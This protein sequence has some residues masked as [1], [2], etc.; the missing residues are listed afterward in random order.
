M[1]GSSEAQRLC[2]MG[3]IRLWTCHP[4]TSSTHSQR[5]QLLRA[6]TQTYLQP[7]T[8]GALTNCKKD[9]HSIYSSVDTASLNWTSG[10]HSLVQAQLPWDLALIMP[11]KARCPLILLQKGRVQPGHSFQ[12]RPQQ[13]QAWLSLPGL[14]SLGPA[15]QDSSHKVPISSQGE[16]RCMGH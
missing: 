3:A 13:P 10:P 4:E 6:R 9:N 12:C 7:R 14:F 2:R 15:V 5:Q 11:G 1:S 16:R 8:S